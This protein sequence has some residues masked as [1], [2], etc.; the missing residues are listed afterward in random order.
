MQQGVSTAASS[1]PS[2]PERTTP[3]VWR[4]GSGR[5]ERRSPRRR[6][7]AGVRVLDGP[8]LGADAS[9]VDLSGDGAFIRTATRL[10]RGAHLRLE[11]ILPTDPRPISVGAQVVRAS[12]GGVGV[13]FEEL[14]A[15]DRAR[16]RSHA[17]FSETDD[18]IARVQRALGDLIP[19]DLLPL[20]DTAEIAAVLDD[21][22]DRRLPV[23]AV[24]AGRGFRHSRA[25]L[26]RDAEGL[27]L[28]GLRRPLGSKDR[29]VYVVFEDRPL[30]YV[31]EGVVQEKGAWPLLLTPERIYLTER[32]SLRRR[33]LR[34]SYL[35]LDA[36]TLPG[37]PLRAEL[38]N[39]SEG[40]ASA[41]LPANL[42]L[43]QGM[44]L[45]SF[46]V[47]TPERTFD[48]DGAVVRHVS[49]QGDRGVRVGLEFGE[50]RAGAHDPFAAR[51]KRLL[52][53]TWRSRMA[54]LG[55]ML[56]AGVRRLLGRGLVDTVA[57]VHVVSYR[58]QRGANVTAILDATFDP[59]S[60]P[61]HVD[62]A[63]V[64]A[65]A[66]LKRKEIFGLL[67]Q[68]LLD[69]LRRDGKAG[70]ILR[71]DASHTV[72]ESTIDP[73]L[74]ARG[75]PYLRWTFSDLEADLVASAGYLERTFRPRARALLTFSVAAIAARRM[76]ADRSG[77][78]IDLWLSPFGCPD[79]QD[80][81]R[82]YLAGL[83]LVSLYQ[84][85]GSA[86]PFL[87]YGRLADPG[88]VIP[89]AIDRGMATLNEARRDMQRIR[90]P[91]VWVV[92]TY[93]YMVTR[94]RVRSLITAPGGGEREVFEVGTGHVLKTGHEA[95]E[96]FKLLYESLARHLFNLD[97]PASEPDLAAVAHRSEV[98][99]ARV[100]RR[101]LGSAAE[102]WERHL[103]GDTEQ[104]EG[105]D[106][107]LRN[108]D[109][110]R[111]MDRQVALMD[112]RP[113]HRIADIGCGTGN[114]AAAIAGAAAVWRS[115]WSL[116][117]I[118]VVRPALE[119]SRQKV[120]E[121]LGRAGA[122]SGGV[123]LDAH[124]IDL[125]QVR[126]H[127]IHEF[128]AGRL[129][130]VEALAGRVEGLERSTL[131]RLSE[132]Y[133]PELHEVLRGEVVTEARLRRVCAGLE[134]HERDQVRDLG[135]AARFA[136]G[137]ERP[138]DLRAGCG[139]ADTAEDLDL[140]VLR[141]GRAT[142][143]GTTSLPAGSFDR[144]GCSLVISYL[145]DPQA[146]MH[147]M[148]RL[149]SSGG[150]LV[151]SSLKPNFDLS[152]P[153]IEEARAIVEDASLAEDE[154]ERLLSSLREFASFAGLVTEL[155]DDGRFRF[156]DGEDLR[157]MAQAAGFREVHVFDGFGDPP[158]A[159]IVMARKG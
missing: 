52:R 119:R 105:Y 56:R 3:S 158:L 96:S 129:Y 125:E 37:G 13:R 86:E 130:S 145:F 68:T 138:E 140:R 27:R 146:A 155:E 102:F 137:R 98:E 111:F 23:T 51:T 46:Q 115:P 35:E 30:H 108:P 131:R 47:R 106:V 93:D 70:V 41:M 149:L 123:T 139:R 61:D 79:A 5:E 8:S 148:F 110:P 17:A 84:G 21:A 91:V 88:F 85:G 53:P 60:P 66:F 72:G 82:N 157:R 50:G 39:L 43:V 112:P 18:A 54:R 103:F 143:S 2:A 29:V 118:D 154:R 151:L 99:W 63:I 65:P 141:F 59:A 33:R 40:G 107:L 153:Y 94:E 113:G 150:V 22:I 62:V 77:P 100:K 114:L 97:R 90:C 36:P 57:D 38:V 1:D 159:A 126:L 6:T 152:K 19:G 101:K 92:G 121:A 49:P 48:V 144:I 89:D 7:N 81:F 95:I 136:L 10:E 78:P 80:M 116:T 42:L 16:I 124:C 26:G 45:P 76:M 11:L 34:G 44:R 12:A 120:E 67:A 9:A 64:V 32:R 14:S 128:L 71:F 117:L 74:E 109:Y 147:E 55:G 156:L 134:D 69:N 135:M 122:D 132:R 83:D 20:S 75:C 58:N 15:R 28:T 87:I 73:E 142:I 104:S 31:F 133:S 127:V 4:P 25:A 24:L